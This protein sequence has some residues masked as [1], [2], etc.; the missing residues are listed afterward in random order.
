[1]NIYQKISQLL[2]YTAI[3][4]MLLQPVAQAKSQADMVSQIG[5]ITTA[6]IQSNTLLTSSKHNKTTSTQVKIETTDEEKLSQL[7]QDIYW[8]LFDWNSGKKAKAF[9]H[10]DM[11]KIAQWL[12]QIDTLQVN[13]NKNLSKLTQW[14]KAKKLSATIMQRQQAAITKINQEITGLKQHL[15]Q[16]KQTANTQQ[17]KSSLDYFKGKQL[18]RKHQ[19]FD[20]LSSVALTPD[21]IA[22]A[23]TAQEFSKYKFAK[24]IPKSN[25]FNNAIYL[26]TS[27]EV[28]INQF[29]QDKATELE[30]DPVKIYHWV[31]NNIEWLPSHGAIQASDITLGSGRGNAFDQ[32]SLLIAMLRAANVPSR[33]AYGTIEVDIDKF[34]NWVGLS[35]PEAALT[36]VQYGAVPISPVIEG[37]VITKVRMEHIWVEA[38]IDFNPSRGAKNITPDSWVALDASF[39]QY[40]VL[41]G[42]D[43]IAISGQ[44]MNQ[45][46]QDFINSGT[47]NETEGWVQ[48]FDPSIL[49]NAQAQMQASLEQHITDNL[50]NPTV[51]DVIGG[52]RTIIM[53]YPTL[54][55]STQNKILLKASDF[56]E[57]QDIMRPKYR[58]AFRKDI[59]GDIVNPLELNFAQ[60][61]NHKLTLSFKPATETDEQALA[62]LIP[63]DAQS[64]DD[65]P[66]SIPA[67]LIR[68]IP[69][70]A[71][72]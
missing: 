24:T 32:S 69:Q 47:T 37:G 10:T 50:S 36:F 3:V 52:R 6:N 23:K 41:T 67:H 27:D 61:N 14:I 33:Y 68:V 55:A 13:V 44:D 39:K 9:K 12:Q 19:V 56:A 15:T 71:L 66:T 17:L 54:P 21:R 26:G 43:P 65:L 45:I 28:V 70:V 35:N 25:D 53:E 5:L 29:I 30:N 46:S 49:T 51:G 8:Q 58:L 16:I 31:R 60:L 48:G 4:S 38:A 22:P 62:A 18:K 7:T 34:T 20:G 72:D 40:E 64:I 63:S 1:M 2:V 57:M 11:Q 59:L 42:L